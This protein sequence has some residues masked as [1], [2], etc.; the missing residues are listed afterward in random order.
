LK[1]RALEVFRESVPHN[2]ETDVP[3]D[4]QLAKIKEAIEANSDKIREKI[5]DLVYKGDISSEVLNDEMIEM[6]AQIMPKP[7]LSVTATSCPGC[8]ACV[9]CVACVTCGACAFCAVCI[10]T[11]TV[12]ALATAQAISAGTTATAATTAMAK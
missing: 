11:G 4:P 9:A 5:W 8:M 12:A 7:D 3:L 1:L 2:A 6:L 10:F